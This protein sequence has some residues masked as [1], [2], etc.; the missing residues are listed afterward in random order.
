MFLLDWLFAII[1][2]LAG[3]LVSPHYAGLSDHFQHP[4]DPRP[5]LPPE[6]MSLWD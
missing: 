5:D 1:D 4:L 3:H 2:W 6:Q